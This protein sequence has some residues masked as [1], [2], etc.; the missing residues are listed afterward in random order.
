MAFGFMDGRPLLPPGGE[1]DEGLLEGAG[2]VG[3][4]IRPSLRLHSAGAPLGCKEIE[5]GSSSDT[6]LCGL[7]DAGSLSNALC[8]A[9]AK[10]LG[11]GPSNFLGVCL[12]N[13]LDDGPATALGDREDMLPSPSEAGVLNKPL[14]NA[15]G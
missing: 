14:C 11:D 4:D 3:G 10:T 5:D 6:V 13:A 12:S 1:D 9:S 2:H 15:G 8:E 7:T